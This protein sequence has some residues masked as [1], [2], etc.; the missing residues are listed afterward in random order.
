M[1]Q[2]INEIVINDIIKNDINKLVIDKPFFTTYDLLCVLEKYLLPC[3]IM[4][5]LD[6]GRTSYY[7]FKKE[8]S[9]QFVDR[10]LYDFYLSL[11]FN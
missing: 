6:I 8:R 3:Q 5:L 7:R 4:K 9:L 2:T 11:D 1:T 10:K